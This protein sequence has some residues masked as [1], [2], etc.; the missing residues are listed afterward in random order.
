[1]AML[2]FLMEASLPYMYNFK[3]LKMH[4]KYSVNFIKPLRQKAVKQTRGLI[5]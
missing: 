1:M 4:N 2:P 5:T 3:T